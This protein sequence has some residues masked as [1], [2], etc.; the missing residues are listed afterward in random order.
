MTIPDRR[1]AK[2]VKSE[3]SEEIDPDTFLFEDDDD[4]DEDDSKLPPERDSSDVDFD[5][6]DW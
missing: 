4:D 1:K 2:A 3:A 6:D 5:D